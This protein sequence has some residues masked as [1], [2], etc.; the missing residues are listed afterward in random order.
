[1]KETATVRVGDIM[2]SSLIFVDGEE[3]A[4]KVAQVMEQKK[5]SGVLVKTEGKYS[6]IITDHDLIIRIV[7]KGL[8]PREI[9][10]E[11]V[12]SSPLI[13]IDEDE[14]IDQ[15]AEKMRG[16]GVRRLVATQSDRVVGVVA[17]SDLIRIEP[18]LHFLIRERSKLEATLT[19]EEPREIVLAGFCE[20]CGNYSKRLKNVDGA[21]LCGECG[22]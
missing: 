5:V 1:M 4:M 13:T 19:P 21:W 15:A 22:N 14:T 8:N 7:S 2:T 17:E 6:G 9:K 10:V 20:E 16:S 12:M 11:A 3:S 18:Q